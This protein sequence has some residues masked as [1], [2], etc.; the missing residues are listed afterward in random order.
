MSDPIGW[1]H[2]RS[3][4]QFA[5]V[6]R[7]VL[8]MKGPESGSDAACARVRQERLGSREKEGA[9]SSFARTPALKE[10]LKRASVT[11]IVPGVDPAWQKVEASSP[12]DLV[13]EAS[14]GSS[15]ARGL[16]GALGRPSPLKV[17]APSQSPR[18][19]GSE[20]L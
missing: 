19:D 7:S 4:S 14:Q 16:L 17:R 5:V 12:R 6:G 11:P 20:A 10:G 13:Y 15:V 18:E 1:P 2:R 9:P 3:S 8:D